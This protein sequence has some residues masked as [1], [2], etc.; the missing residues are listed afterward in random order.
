MFARSEFL[1][2]VCFALCLQKGRLATRQ[3]CEFQGRIAKRAKEQ[4][5]F[6]PH[7][8]CAKVPK[9]LSERRLSFVRQINQTMDFSACLGLRSRRTGLGE[10]GLGALTIS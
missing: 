3:T 8:G 10:R 1:K 9:Q 5:G 6:R 4:Q 7:S 2:H